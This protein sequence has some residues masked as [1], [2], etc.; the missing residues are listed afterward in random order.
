MRR[1]RTTHDGEGGDGDE[2][3]EGED[4]EC[5]REEPERLGQVVVLD[6]DV[7]PSSRCGRRERGED[8][9]RGERGQHPGCRYAAQ[10]GVRPLVG[11]LGRLE[12][13]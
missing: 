9:G 13:R 11:G 2:E 3:E 4:A 1:R 6:D 12:W 7:A 5:A 10:A 8:G